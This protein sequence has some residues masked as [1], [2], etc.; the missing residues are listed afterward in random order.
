MQME[1]IVMSKLEIGFNGDPL[2][3]EMSLVPRGES[4][5]EM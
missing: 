1:N 4:E 2:L 5:K 3:L